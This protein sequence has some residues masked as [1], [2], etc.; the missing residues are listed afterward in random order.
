[1]EKLDP[2]VTQQ[3]SYFLTNEE[4]IWLPQMISLENRPKK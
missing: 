3:I 2:T 1:M 4:N